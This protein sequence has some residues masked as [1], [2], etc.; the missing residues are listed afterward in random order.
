MGVAKSLSL[1]LLEVG[2]GSGGGDE[3][4]EVRCV[5]ERRD[6]RGTGIA[7]C[8]LSSLMVA[9]FLLSQRERQRERGKVG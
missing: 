1:D 3:V 6:S 7:M 2:E 8:S 9:A 5:V 4:G